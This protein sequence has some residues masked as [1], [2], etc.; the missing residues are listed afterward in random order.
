MQTTEKQRE[1]SGKAQIALLVALA[2]VSGAAGV[3]SELKAAP[4]SNNSGYEIDVSAGSQTTNTDGTISASGIGGTFSENGDGTATVSVFGINQLVFYY[5]NFTVWQ[6]LSRLSAFDP[7]NTTYSQT[8][9]IKPGMSGKQT[10]SGNGSATLLG[11]VFDYSTFTDTPVTVS[12]QLAVDNTANQASAFDNHTLNV[13]NDPNTGKVTASRVLSSG[14]AAF[15]PTAGSIS[16]S[17]NGEV[18]AD[19]TGGIGQ[20]S[21]FKNHS[22]TRIQ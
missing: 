7:A 17:V 16:V 10:G 9:S 5:P 14:V 21:I 1:D 4:V 2:M 18:Y 6:N 8:V 22:V 3:W 13:S 12:L 11:D 15:G 20:V 19:A